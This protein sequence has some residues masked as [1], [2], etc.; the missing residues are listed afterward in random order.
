MDDREQGPWSWGR[1]LA[2][3]SARLP[4]EALRFLGA[5]HRRR[6]VAPPPGTP[7]GTFVVAD[8]A[9]PTRIHWMRWDAERFEEGAVEPGGPIA[10]LAARAGLVTWI[11]V[12]GLGSPD[13]LEA[14]GETFEIH[15]LALADVSHVPQRPKAEMHEDRLLIVTQMASLTGDR[16]IEVDQ[17]SLVLGPGFVITFQERPSPLFEPVRE[18]VRTPKAKVRSMGAD[19]LAYTLVDTVIDGF[20]P[21]VEAIGTVLEEL[22]EEVVI[23]PSAEALARIHATRRTLLHLHRIQWRQRDAVATL[24]RDADLPFS[25]PVRIYLRDAHDHAF[26]TVD[27]IETYRDMSVGLMDVYLSSASNRLNEVMKTLTIMA[28]VFI[29]LSFVAG[30]Y[31]MNFDRMPELHWR[32]GYPTVWAIMIVIAASLM[33]WFWRRGWLR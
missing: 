5:P 4:L 28:S 29:P 31:G 16:Q 30:V 18:R 32:W 11:D 7:A 19:F 14:L 33:G 20:F 21:V 12:Q 8:S 22:E 25:Q 2:L 9:V 3:R 15:P 24:L 6:R 10:D 26:Q 17:V 13:V 23:G 1:R 27:A